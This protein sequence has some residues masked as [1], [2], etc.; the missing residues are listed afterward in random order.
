MQITGHSG[1]KDPFKSYGR[2]LL[3]VVRFNRVLGVLNRI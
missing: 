1:M 2:Y 3:D